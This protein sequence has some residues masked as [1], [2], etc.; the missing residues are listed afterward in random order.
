MLACQPLRAKKLGFK[1]NKEIALN[2]VSS[3]YSMI[4]FKIPICKAGKSLVTKIVNFQVFENN[5]NKGI[6]ST[7]RIPYM[8]T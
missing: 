5:S 4:V 2:H 6:D 1:Y 7:M 8:C 3:Q